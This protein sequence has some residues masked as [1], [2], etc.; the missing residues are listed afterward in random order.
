MLS[1]LAK[2]G[3]SKNIVSSDS[4]IR[5]WSCNEIEVNLY[6]NICCESCDSNHYYNSRAMKIVNVN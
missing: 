2:E 5:S 4:I 6:S 1:L 3:F